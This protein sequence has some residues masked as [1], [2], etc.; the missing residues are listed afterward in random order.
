LFYLQEHESAVGT[1]GKLAI[2]SGCD[3]PISQFL[4]ALKV[5]GFRTALRVTAANIKKA[6]AVGI[7]R[8]RG[9]VGPQ[10]LGRIKDVLQVTRGEAPDTKPAVMRQA[11][12]EAVIGR[13]NNLLHLKRQ[14]LERPN[15]TVRSDFT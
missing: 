1:K 4:A 7:E 9:V 3:L 10:S 5:P 11:R 12:N 13:E 8:N 2:G 14:P 15:S 6:V